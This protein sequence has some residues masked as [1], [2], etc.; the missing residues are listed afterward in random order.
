MSVLE[1]VSSVV[2]LDISASTAVTMRVKEAMGV[3]TVTT[4]AMEVA[5][6]TVEVMAGMV[7]TTVAMSDET[8]ATWTVVATGITTIA[9]AG[10]TATAGATTEVHHLHRTGTR[11]ET[12]HH[13]C[14]VTIPHVE[15]TVGHVLGRHHQDGIIQNPEIMVTVKRK[16]V[17]GD[18]LETMQ[19]L[20]GHLT[21]QGIIMEEHLLEAGNNHYMDLLLDLLEASSCN[22]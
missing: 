22:F 21:V 6:T 13:P 8:T 14:H 7:G 4:E 10:Q 9:T 17:A 11:Q 20:P 16:L 3:K 19:N 5:G 18:L 2:N 15:G 1:C 12:C